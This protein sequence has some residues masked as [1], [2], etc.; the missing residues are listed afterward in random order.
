MTTDMNQTSGGH[1]KTHY[2][3]KTINGN[4]TFTLGNSQAGGDT[5]SFIFELTHT[6]G[7][8]T[9]PSKIKWAHSQTPTLTAGKVH[10]IVL[11]SSAASAT[12]DWRGAAIADFAS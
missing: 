11:T 2:I 10:L 12:G 4:T 3:K 8:I 1:N 7:T 5:T 6:S 9:W